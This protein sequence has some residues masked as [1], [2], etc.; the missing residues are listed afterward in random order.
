MIAFIADAAG[1]QLSL[2]NT[3]QGESNQLKMRQM[4]RAQRVVRVLQGG[5]QSAELVTAEL[6]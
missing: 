3:I 4:E 5:N 2:N 1:S 6:R